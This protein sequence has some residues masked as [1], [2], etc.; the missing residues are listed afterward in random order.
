LDSVYR[1]TDAKISGNGAYVAFKIN[2]GFDTLRTCELKKIDKKKWPK[3]SLGIYY[4]AND[5][6]VKMEKIKSFYLN[7]EDDWGVFVFDHNELKEDKKKK[8]ICKKK[9][10]KDYESKGNYVMIFH[11]VNGKK[12][13]KDIVDFDTS[14]KANIVALINHQKSEGDSMQVSILQLSD[15]SQYNLSPRHTSIENMVLDEAGSKL[16]YLV[17]DDSTKV[18]NYHLR[19][20]DISGKVESILVD[21]SDLQ[22]GKE[23]SVSMNYQPFFSKEGNRLFFGAAEW[24][25]EEPKDTLLDSEKVELDIWHYQDKRLQPQQLIEKKRD[26]KSTDLFIYHLDKGKLVQLSND[27]LETRAPQREVGNLIVGVSRERYM[28]EDNWNSPWASDYYLI[29]LEDGSNKLVE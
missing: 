20:L 18:K 21:S 9:R 29:N 12:E 24:L 2:P 22:F 16:A 15:F 23:R 17:S 26:E 28:G 14:E 19:I 25:K 13:Y 4:T 7:D 8:H 11:P 10:P 27:T 1:G 6:L 5:S 3:D